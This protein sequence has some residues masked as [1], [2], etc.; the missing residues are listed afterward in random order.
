LFGVPDVRRDPF[1]VDAVGLG[2]IQELQS[3]PVLGAINDVVGNA[4]LATTLAI[5]A[6]AF[7]EKKFRVQ[8]GAEARV[9]GAESELHGDDTVGGLA[10]AAAIL[11]LHARSFLAGLGM[12]GVVDDAD[13]LRVFMIARYELLNAIPGAGMVPDIAVKI[14]LQRA[15]SDVVE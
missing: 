8:H 2:T 3:N 14:F 1:E 12:T 13:G 6:P 7:G 4:R 5:V 11:P 15:R 10:E 9:V